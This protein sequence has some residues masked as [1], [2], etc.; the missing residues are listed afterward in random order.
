MAE[1]SVDMSKISLGHTDFSVCDDERPAR[2]YALEC[3]RILEEIMTKLCAAFD[4]GGGPNPAS[5]T[6]SGV[7][8]AVVALGKEYITTDTALRKLWLMSKR[9][10]NKYAN[11]RKFSAV[12]G[13]FYD[14]I[15]ETIGVVGLTAQLMQHYTEW[16]HTVGLDIL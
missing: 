3:R 5:V 6:V 11:I 7:R 15:R 1:S 8:S 14:H 13:K 12:C 2:Y 10:P 16:R 4:I 9:G